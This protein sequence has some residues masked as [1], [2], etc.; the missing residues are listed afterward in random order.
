MHQGGHPRKGIVDLIPIHPISKQTSLEDCAW[1]AIRISQQL[2]M[3]ENERTKKSN[4]ENIDTFLFGHADIPLKRSLV[5]M[6][7]HVNW[8]S[9]NE[10]GMTLI[11]TSNV[12]V[13]MFFST[14]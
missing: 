3:T 13:F 2:R 5:T 10:K 6:R 7:K 4:H 11:N 1:V 9:S 8:Y 14:C 12:Q